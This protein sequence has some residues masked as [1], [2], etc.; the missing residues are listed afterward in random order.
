MDAVYRANPSV[1]IIGI[2][3]EGSSLYNYTLRF[4]YSVIPGPTP[5]DFNQSK[6]K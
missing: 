5:V 2:L 1:N 3:F 6:K 4:D